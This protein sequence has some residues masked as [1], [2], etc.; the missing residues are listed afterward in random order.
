[1]TSDSDSLEQKLDEIK[2]NQQTLLN[3]S[4][5]HLQL[6]ASQIDK[7]D[8][9]NRLFVELQKQSQKYQRTA[10]IFA[11]V[12]VFAVAAYVVLMGL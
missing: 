4:K 8:E 1:M 7:T 2:A 6:Y 10:I 9:L 12:T 11:L 5:K 3:L